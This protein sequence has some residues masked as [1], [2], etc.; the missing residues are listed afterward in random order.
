M[1]RRAVEA[2]SV[3]ALVPLLTADPLMLRNGPFEPRSGRPGVPGR[4]AGG[5]AFANSAG[6]R[7]TVGG[8]PNLKKYSTRHRPVEPRSQAEADAIIA[9]F[10]RQNWLFGGRSAV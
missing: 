8:L 6:G 3:S 1:S 2:C 9:R 5:Q 10:H 7:T 4:H